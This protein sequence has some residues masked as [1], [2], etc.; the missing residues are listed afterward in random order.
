MARPC[1]VSFFPLTRL[2]QF[3]SRSSTRQF[4]T[5]LRTIPS[6][7]PL[8]ARSPTARRVAGPLALAALS[9][10]QARFASTQPAPAPADPIPPAA[11]APAAPAPADADFS[12][13]LSDLLGIDNVHDIP[14]QIGFL[15]GLGLDYGWGPTSSME[16]LIE[17]IY[18]YT[19]LP[20]WA[21]LTVTAIAVRA[22][23]FKPTISSQIESQKMQDLRKNP[24]YA[25][26]QARMKATMQSGDRGELM[27]V[28]NEIRNIH[29][30]MEL[31]WWK[32]AIP[33]LQVPVGFGM[34]RLVRGM[35]D[36]PVPSLETGGVLWF[37]NLAVP[38]PYYLLPLAAAGM[39]VVS[40]RVGSSEYP[41]GQ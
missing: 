11:P 3:L 36:L 40:M 2:V 26:L 5:A 31:K 19:G 37:Q 21:T 17:H 41:Y 4:G 6:R 9:S 12:T 34:L 39:F 38:D 1:L 16:W 20:W 28:R 14:E 32:I 10:R 27:A 24:K 25:A 15:K 30:A 22:A 7:T 29:K 13:S 35:A 8:T 18:V 33:M 23:I